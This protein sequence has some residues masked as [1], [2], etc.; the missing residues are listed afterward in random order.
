MISV[1]FEQ[2]EECKKLMKELGR[3]HGMPFLGRNEEDESVVIWIFKDRISVQTLQKN[4]WLRTNILWA[5]GTREELFD[6]EA[7]ADAED[8]V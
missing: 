3:E 4:G 5:D 6:K 8:N 1:D 7:P 2:F